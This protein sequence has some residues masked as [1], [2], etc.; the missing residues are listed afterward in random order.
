MSFV[1]W[2][3][4][5]DATARVITTVKSSAKIVVQPCSDGGDDIAINRTAGEKLIFQNKYV[6]FPT[7]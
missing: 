4:V 7:I 3:V 1:G 6:I 5:G 2:Q